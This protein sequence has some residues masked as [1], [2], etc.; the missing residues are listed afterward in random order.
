MQYNSHPHTQAHGVRSIQRAHLS[1]GA[2]VGSSAPNR[3]RPWKKEDELGRERERGEREEREE[4]E[5][6]RE[7]EEAEGW[8]L[9]FGPGRMRKRMSWTVDRMREEERR[10]AWERGGGVSAQTR[11]PSRLIHHVCKWP[12]HYRRAYSE[13]TASERRAVT[14]TP[15]ELTGR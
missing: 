6:E 11:S 5:R 2:G 3:A 1:A 13:L 10:A 8:L 14:P 12:H 7:R 15:H 4:R 9:C